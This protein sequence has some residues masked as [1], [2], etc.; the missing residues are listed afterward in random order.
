V[1]SGQ[2]EM[3]TAVTLFRE[4]AYD[5]L[6]KDEDTSDRLWQ[7]ILNIKEI[8]KLKQQIKELKEARDI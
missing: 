3:E 4:G 2:D 1:I 5:Y 7:H 6:I 8:M